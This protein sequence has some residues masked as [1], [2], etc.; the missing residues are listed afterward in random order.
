[1]E[2]T[3]LNIEVSAQKITFQDNGVGINKKE[4]PYLFEKFYQGK[5]EKTGNAENRGIGVGLS[6]VKKICDLHD[7][8]A[9]IIS[10]IHKGFI[11]EVYFD[12]ES[13]T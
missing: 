6:M 10:D 8:K 4:L 3:E 9:R 12:I 1:G 7:W 5:K 2:N 11:L 13:F